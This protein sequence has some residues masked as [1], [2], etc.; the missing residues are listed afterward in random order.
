[1]LVSSS[2]REDHKIQSDIILRFFIPRPDKP[3]EGPVMGITHPKGFL[4][5]AKTYTAICHL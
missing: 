3:V 1:M 2:S 5:I 4:L